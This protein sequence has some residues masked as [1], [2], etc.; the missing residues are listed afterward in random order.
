VTGE[1]RRDLDIALL[2]ATG[3][4]GG[5]AAEYLADHAHDARW[6]LAG[7]NRAALEALRERLDLDVPILDADVDDG[8][9]LRRLAAS[10]RVLVTTV[11]PYLR[12]GAPVVA[13]CAAA[14]TDYLD[15]TGEPEFVDRMY[16]GHHATAARTG[17]RLVHSCGFDSI[18]FDLGVLF[19]VQHLPADRPIG[20][21]GYV[22]VSGRPSG[23]TLATIVDAV[24]RRRSAAEAHAERRRVEPRPAG[25][26]VRALAGR[27]GYEPAVG[28]WVAPLPTIDPQVVA[29]SARAMDRYGPDFTYHHYAAVRN[30]ATAAGL[31]T[32]AL[33]L[34]ALG[35]TAPT[36][37]LAGRLAGWLVAP[38]HGP[39]VR[40][41][42]KS[43]FRARFVGTAGDT[44][45]VTE[46]AGGD[47]GYGETA[48]MLAESALCLAFDRLPAT[49]GQ[50]TTAVAMGDALR[51]RLERAGITF[52]VLT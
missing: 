47:P 36:R 42:E 19:T 50:V 29:R 33:G 46:V 45:V 22:S 10:T 1:R 32:G 38:G 41:R 44:R 14:G 16:V 7:R 52:R 35:Q 21:R 8:A 30:P 3:F 17:A 48:K 2:G 37:A 12:Y 18:P 49:A 43:W 20:V 9:S 4:T 11:G 25:R 13:A 51:I 5:L 31:A 6:A 34:L 40:R 26:R 15:L 23:G 27:A 24:P 28:A 39:S